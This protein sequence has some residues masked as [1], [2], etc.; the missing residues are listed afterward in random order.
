MLFCHQVLC[1]SFKSLAYLTIVYVPGCWSL[2]RM[3]IM[4]LS[5]KII[6]TCFIPTTSL[7]Q[8]YLHNL[9]AGEAGAQGLGSSKGGQARRQTCGGRLD[10]VCSGKSPQPFSI[11]TARSSN[12]SCLASKARLKLS[13]NAALLSKQWSCMETTDWI[14][15]ASN[16]V[17]CNDYMM[18]M[19]GPHSLPVLHVLLCSQSQPD[20]MYACFRVLAVVY[21]NTD[22]VSCHNACFD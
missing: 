15:D 2:E 16:F 12:L 5:I 6:L 1:P 20:V 11:N 18:S 10:Q 22:I 3:F 7:K 8:I 13:L 17:L 9:A 21:A 4:V 19:H 14:L